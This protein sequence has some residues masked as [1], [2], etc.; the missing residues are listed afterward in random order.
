MNPPPSAP[1]APADVLLVEDDPLLLDQM[2]ELLGLDG[3]SV[4]SASSAVDALTLLERGMAPAVLVTDINLAG[5]LSGLNLARIVA[6]TWPAIRLVI[7]SGACRPPA[8]QYP[9]GAIFFTKPFASGAL[10]AIVR[11]TDW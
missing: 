1:P 5:Q 10:T 3:L 4:A 2:A 7:V 6:E 11:S 8:D 9:S